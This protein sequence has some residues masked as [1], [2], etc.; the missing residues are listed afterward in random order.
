[1]EDE[2]VTPSPDYIKGF[3]E[4]YLLTTHS[5]DL[6]DKLVS[7]KGDGE[8]M[9]G[10]QDGYKQVLLDKIREQRPKSMTDPEFLKTIQNNDKD[11]DLDK[12]R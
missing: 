9:Q 2:T 6:A 8:R 5:R 10:F 11:R 3:N 4:G 1:M 7:A 12:S